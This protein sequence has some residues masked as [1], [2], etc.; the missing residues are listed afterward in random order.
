[1]KRPKIARAMDYL[2]DDLIEGAL[3]NTKISEKGARTMKN[4]IWTKVAAV[5]AGLAILV[6]GG[7]MVTN[8]MGVNASAVVALD[9]NP[10]IEIEVNGKEKVVDVDAL[11]A[12]AELVLGEMDLINVDLDVAI[13]AIIGSMYTNN[14]LT[15]EQ[16]SILISVDC[17]SSV[18]ATTLQESISQEVTAL[19]AGHNIEAS[20]IT[21][22]FEKGNPQ[23]NGQDVSAAKA[24]LIEKIV[25]AGIT[26]NDGIPYTYEQLVGLKV[27]ELKQMLESKNAQVGGIQSSGNAGKGEY[28]GKQQAL[29]I[30]YGQA[31]VSAEEAKRV[32]VELDF[33]DDTK[34][35]L[36][37]IEFEVGELEYEYDINATTGEIVKA[38]TEAADDGYAPTTPPEGN[39]SREDALNAAYAKAGVTA[40]DVR[41]VD[42][43]FKSFNGRT[44]YSVE[45]DVG[46]TEYEYTVD[47]TTGEILR[48]K[49]ESDDATAP[50][51][52]IGKQAALEAAYAHAGVNASDARDVECEL[53]TINGSSRFSIEFEANGKEYEYEVNATTGEI[54]SSHVEIDD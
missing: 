28:I 20:V 31:G 33:D 7:V 38:K 19:L 11:N 35:M 37:E 52:G 32:E 3:R 5:A 18:K 42:C 8:Y 34:T 29:D 43:E 17:R 53:E 1:M 54:I 21:Q 22:T 39:I 44:Y 49:I 40:A 36:Y 16:N 12:E 15:A 50:E 6:T 10:S 41:D 25:A 48:E 9:V 24:A 46:A 14:F 45:F 47:A 2:D 4:S 13:N 30:A 51:N 26:T 27:N 23:G